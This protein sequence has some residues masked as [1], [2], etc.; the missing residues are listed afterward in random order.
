M[1][2]RL[3]RRAIVAAALAPVLGGLTACDPAGAPLP[4]LPKVAALRAP[5]SALEV[6]TGPPCEGV[7]RIRLM[8]TS[9]DGVIV[10]TVAES[11]QPH[12]VEQLTVGTAPE[13]FTVTEPLPA[14]FDWREFDELSVDVG[15]GE[16][17]VGHATVPLGEVAAD[18]GAHADDGATYVPDA[19]WLSADEITARDG[20]EFLMLCTPE[21]ERS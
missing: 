4:E 17:W 13:G 10:R 15:P 7:T 21:P 12:T 14:G 19:G 6:L 8:F 3:A 9:D 11:V 16:G 20:E 1:H 5:A 2:G 18:G